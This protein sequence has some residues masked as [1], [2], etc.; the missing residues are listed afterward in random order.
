[1]SHPIFL[2]TSREAD[3]IFAPVLAGINLSVF[4]LVF[5]TRY[6]FDQ[7][8]TANKFRGI[9]FGHTDPMFVLS[10]GVE[11]MID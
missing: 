7:S 3:E 1:M 8:I 4:F 2:I 10:Y 11:A 9:D 6:F 5:A